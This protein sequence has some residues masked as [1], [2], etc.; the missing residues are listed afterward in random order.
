MATVK[1]INS[2]KKKLSCKDFFTKKSLSITAMIYAV[3]ISLSFIIVVFEKKDVSKVDF[4]I[5][6]NISGSSPTRLKDSL[7]GFA[8]SPNIG[9]ISLNSADCT[10]DNGAFSGNP[11]G[12]PPA[13][14]SFFD[15]GVNVN[16]SGNFLR[17]DNS[18]SYAW[19][20]NAGWIDFAPSGSYP[21]NPAIPAHLDLATGLITGWAQI[22]SLGNDGW[23]KM[24]KDPADSGSAYGVT[25]DLT[26]G[27]LSG[28]AW[29]GNNNGSGAGWISFN[30][31]DCDTDNNNFVDS[32]TCGGVD[33]ATTPVID[34]SADT[35]LLP[36]APT[37]GTIN[38]SVNP[39]DPCK[40]VTFNWIDNSNN[41]AGFH[42]QIS[43]NLAGPW[44]DIC[45][46]AST[47]PNLTSCTTNAANPGNSYYFRVRAEN[48]VFS[49]NW[50]TTGQTPI[51]YCSAIVSN[52]LSANYNCDHVLLFW[53]Q[54]SGAS[55][56][57]VYRKEDAGSF[58][59]ITGSDIQPPTVTSY[60][61]ITITSGVS[62]QYYI[63][64]HYSDGSDIDSNIIGPINP[65]PKLP[66][67][68][69]TQSQ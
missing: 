42:E 34:Y 37:G 19:S 68:K 20:S 62:Y 25:M 32:G 9:W 54:P 43:S 23:V 5:A 14:T 31:K 51:G 22:V 45:S 3:A 40:T 56:Y 50:L 64:T 36:A 28:F 41:E 17:S 6:G 10:D 2:N 26:T 44:S 33:N 30:S 29:N 46:S 8:W 21:G 47:T 67:W 63:T 7:S 61:D 69:E 12:C 66:K 39:S 24:R 27:K 53:T 60:D 38:Q 59:K 11:A 35:G 65:C 16:A 52:P 58:N 15:Y 18:H 57:N 13:G 49:S 1:K 55:Y 48:G 4:A